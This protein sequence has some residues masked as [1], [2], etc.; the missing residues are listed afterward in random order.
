MAKF[1]DALLKCKG[2]P[3]LGLI[4][5]GTTGRGRIHSKAITSLEKGLTP[6][7]HAAN[8]RLLNKYNLRAKP[9]AHVDSSLRFRGGRPRKDAALLRRM[10][11]PQG[12]K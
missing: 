11:K 4:R 12:R 9:I 7:A 6:V 10:L 2:T 1:R 5:Q 3:V 8:K